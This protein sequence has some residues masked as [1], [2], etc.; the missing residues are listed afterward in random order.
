MLLRGEMLNQLLMERKILKKCFQNEK[1]RFRLEIRK[2]KC[3][4]GEALEQAA[5]GTC[6]CPIPGS[7]QDQS[8]LVYLKCPCPQQGA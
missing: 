4:G 6:G 3:E 8:D 1:S 5:H 7:V 2:K